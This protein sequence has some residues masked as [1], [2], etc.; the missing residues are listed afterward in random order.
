MDALR[1]ELAAMLA[2]ADH[3]LAERQADARK[4]ERRTTLVIVAGGAFGLLSGM[5]AA[6][7]FAMAIASRVRRLVQEARDVAAGR[8][9]VHEVKGGD[10]I[11]VLERTLQETSELLTD[12]AEQLRKVH[13]ELETR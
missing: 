4:M 10:E 3:V 5:L 11:A 13:G 12:R 9:I 7:L 8:P 2:D 1:G 6:L